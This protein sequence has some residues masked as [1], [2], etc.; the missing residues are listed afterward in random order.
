MGKPQ[1]RT[2]PDLLDEIVARE[3]DRVF[4]IDG[5]TRLTY[6]AFRDEVRAYAK[7]FLAMGVR[8]G[9]RVAILMGNRTEWLTGYFAAMAIGAEVVALNTRAT[10]R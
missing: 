7:G 4:L 9:G 3:A 6:R 10:A 8:K 2:A 1:S 5:E